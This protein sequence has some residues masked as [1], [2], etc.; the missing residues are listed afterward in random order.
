MEKILILGGSGLVGKALIN[1]LKEGYDVYG[2]YASSLITSLPDDKQFQLKVQEINKLVELVSFIQPDIVISC[3]RGDFDQQ[4]KFHEKLAEVLQNTKSSLYFFSTT[5]VFDGDLSKP[6][7]ET[8]TP[9]AESDYGKYKIECENRLKEVL[10]DRAI[11][12]RIP[13]IWGKNSRRWNEINECIKNNESID[14]YS[15]IVWNNLLDVDLASQLRFILEKKLKGIFHLGTADP[16]MQSQFYEQILSKLADETDL[17]RYN[18]YEDNSQTYYFV[19]NT[20][21]NDNHES[22]QR[23]NEDIISYLLGQ[24]EGL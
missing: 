19:L 20:N 12:L 24:N 6:H 1:E 22:L 5:N 10:A 18:M 23:T 21:R 4:L 16:I 15:N 9:I 13:A 2:T 14:V 17:L 11:I 7:T 8:D 3:L